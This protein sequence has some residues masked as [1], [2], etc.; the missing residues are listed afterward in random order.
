MLDVKYPEDAKP[1]SLLRNGRVYT[2][3]ARLERF[4]NVVEVQAINTRGMG[5][6]GHIALPNDYETLSA[7][8]RA[9][10][11]MA[12]E[13]LQRE[14]AECP[15]FPLLDDVCKTAQDMYATDTDD[16]EIDDDANISEADDGAW[17][18]AYV[19]VPRTEIK[20][21]PSPEAA[22]AAANKATCIYCGQDSDLD[23]SSRDHGSQHVLCGCEAEWIEYSDPNSTDETPQVMEVEIIKIPGVTDTEEAAA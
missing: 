19:W 23:Y 21:A 20:A 2:T 13:A 22:V 15:T 10:R 3:G 8:E 6:K 1:E 9:F 17:V 12:R 16:I 5:A 14:Q 4:G 18:Q 7:M 11:Q